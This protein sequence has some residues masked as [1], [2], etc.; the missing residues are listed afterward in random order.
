M[1][2]V[3][4]VPC[5]NEEQTIA[6]VVRDFARELPDAD[7]V[8]YDNNSSD[9]TAAIARR[10][11][12]MVH[13]ETRQG[14]GNV[15][16]AMFRDIDADV[17]IMVDGD[18][19]YP[20]EAVH[21]LIDAVSHGADMAIGDRLSNGSYGQAND[22]RFHELGNSLVRSLI[23][24]LFRSE[25][26][27]IMSGYRAF[28][29]RFVKNIPVESAGFEIETELTLH[30]LDKRMNIVE[31]PIDYRDRP[32]GSHSKLNTVRDGFRVVRFIG[33]IFKDYRPFAFF[34]SIAGLFLIAG[35]ATGIPVV[36]EYA[37]TGLV[38]KEPSAVLSTGFMLLAA[39]TFACAIILDT[40][41]KHFRHAQEVTIMQFSALDEAGR[42]SAPDARV[43]LNS[44][45]NHPA[46]AAA[47]RQT[48][49]R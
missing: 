4:L 36:V 21:S 33:R 37:Q 1:R 35:L 34:A 11:G 32:E 7:I 45:T 13:R 48:S 3:V 23:N 6:K 25:L 15:V 14:K 5:Y 18:D 22:R 26:R 28:S 10:E 16:R 42:A 30:A 43:R 8:V 39:L 40:M 41:V 49:A 27:D 2:T 46:D 12:A 24:T 31:I 19:T 29:R 9:Q 44:I 38:H 20:A 17:Y 47:N